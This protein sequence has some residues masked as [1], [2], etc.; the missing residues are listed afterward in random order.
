MITQNPILT[1]A[2][3]NSIKKKN[4]RKNGTLKK[5]SKPAIMDANIMM[6]LLMVA[7]IRLVMPQWHQYAQ[8]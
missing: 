5:S 6:K 1:I 2:K 7:S 3:A 8:L 4:M